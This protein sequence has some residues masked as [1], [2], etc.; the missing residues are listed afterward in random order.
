MNNMLVLIT[1]QTE[2]N[3]F[4]ILFVGWVKCPFRKQKGR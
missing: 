3:N 2:D 1:L 4:K